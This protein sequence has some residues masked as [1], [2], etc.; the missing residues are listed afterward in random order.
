MKYIT[1]SP[2]WVFE[3]IEKGRVIYVVDKQAKECF[4][5]ND[6]DVATAVLLVKDAKAHSD[7]YDFWYEE[8][9]KVTDDA[10]LR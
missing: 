7:K 1:V 8:E 2:F 5:L 9:I 10:E 3:D 4:I 6:L